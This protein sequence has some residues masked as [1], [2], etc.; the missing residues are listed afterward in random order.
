MPPVAFGLAWWLS[1]ESIAV[2]GG[3][4][5]LAGA[6]IALWRWHRGA[7][8]VAVVGSLL[9]VAV[10]AVIALRTGE[11]AHFFLLRLATNAASALVWLTSI[12][13]R[14]PLLGVVVG[15][16]LGQGTR[17]RR[18]PELLRAYQ[19][20]SWVW[21]GQYAVRLVVFVPLWLAGMVLPLSVAQAVL[22]WPLVVATLAGSWWVIRRSLSGE[23]PGIR[24]PVTE[25]AHR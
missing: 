11:A 4:A 24:H 22:S 15:G 21:V 25:P 1:G 18:D 10:A 12:A 5:V 23:H 6:V 9:A 2:G 19:R 3:V 17:W 16:V 14:W 20:A 8:P 7:R 13:V